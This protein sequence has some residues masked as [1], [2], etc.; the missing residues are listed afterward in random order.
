VILGWYRDMH[1]LSVG[2]NASFLMHPDFQSAIIDCHKQGYILPLESIQ[3]AIAQTKLALA[4]STPL[5][6]CLENL[7]LSLNLY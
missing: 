2:G 3:K 4:R 7:F 6:N 5:S 1:L